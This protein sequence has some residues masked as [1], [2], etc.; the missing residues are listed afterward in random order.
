MARD[1]HSAARTTAFAHK[2]RKS[3]P[4][5]SS[6]SGHG[7]T[8]PGAVPAG[9]RSSARIGPPKRGGDGVLRDFAI[10]QNAI[11]IEDDHSP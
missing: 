2:R 7:H 5:R 3:V 9:I 8:N 11:A 6:A 4:A 10:H 1:P